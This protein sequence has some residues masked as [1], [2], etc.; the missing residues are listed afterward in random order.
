MLRN[1]KKPLAL[2]IALIMT[3]AVYAYA[4]ETPVE[5]VEAEAVETVEAVE[6]LDTVETVETV[7]KSLFSGEDRG[8][9][10]IKERSTASFSMSR[11]G[12]IAWKTE[13]Y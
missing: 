7:G 10:S 6:A 8:A 13:R 5:T 9:S 2:S 3:S 1:F 11:Q 4:E 12:V